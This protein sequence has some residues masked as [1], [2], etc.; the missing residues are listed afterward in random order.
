MIRVMRAETLKLRRSLVAFV[1]GV[2]PVMTFILTVLVQL[3]GESPGIWQFQM[4]ATAGIW[5]Y[6][7]LPMTATGLTAL[8]AQ[9]EHGPG[10]WS[11]AR[12]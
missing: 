6:F 4:M 5:A 11:R 12:L 1:L 3:S 9:M 8:L 2:P 7:L 10:T